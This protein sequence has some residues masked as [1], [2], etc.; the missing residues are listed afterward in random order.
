MNGSRRFRSAVEMVDRTRAYSLDEAV[1]LLQQLP[2][3]KFDET[4]E[5]GMQLGVDP[6]KSEQMVRGT[7]ALPHGT[8]KTVRVV[9]ICQG[10]QAREAQEAGAEHTGFSD[11][12]EKIQGGW[13]DFDVIVAAPD[14]MREVGK[15]GKLLGPRGL[16]PSPKTGTVTPNVGQAVREVKAG[17]I[18]FKIDKAGNLH[19]PIGK[20]SFAPD[21]LVANGAA[22]FDAVLKAKPSSSR[23]EYLKSATLSS[24]MGP[25][26]RLDV[27][28]IAAQGR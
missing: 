16:M 19:L 21:K 13:L 24:T 12:V 6:R 1:V 18:E 10:D 4:V 20:A 14:T 7:V 8:G 15:L 2:K 23:G 26:I 9:A 28:A 17:K 11:I 22:A 25:G 27:K 5:V 3:A